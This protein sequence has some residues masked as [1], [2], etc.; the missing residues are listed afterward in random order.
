MQNGHKLYSI[1]YSPLER[2]FKMSKHPK[3][4]NILMKTEENYTYIKLKITNINL[5]VL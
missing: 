1:K 2:P 5:K 3:L 4:G